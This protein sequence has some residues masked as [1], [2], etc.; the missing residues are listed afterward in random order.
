LH[1]DQDLNTFLKNLWNVI[2]NVVVLSGC[3]SIVVVGFILI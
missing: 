2:S 1:K 3:C